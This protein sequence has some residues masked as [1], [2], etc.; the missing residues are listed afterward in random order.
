MGGIDSKDGDLVG[1]KEL[2]ELYKKYSKVLPPG[3]GA[4]IN[5]IRADHVPETTVCRYFGQKS[6]KSG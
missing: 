4:C 2:S 6:S 3:P 1:A 5:D